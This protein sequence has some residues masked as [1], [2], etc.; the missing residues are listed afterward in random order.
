[1]LRNDDKGMATVEMALSLLVLAPLLM[2]LMEGANALSQ[3][4]QLLGASREGARMVLRED[5]ET[6]GVENLVKSLTE[7]LPGPDVTVQTTLD[8]TN[9][10][11][12]TVTVKVDYVYQ[13]L[14]VADSPEEENAF[15]NIFGGDDLTFHASTTMPLP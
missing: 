9:P 3:Y 10:V 6:A 8:T 14:I 15:W 4:S 1:M 12:N 2:L 13:P 7:G 5:G 11:Q